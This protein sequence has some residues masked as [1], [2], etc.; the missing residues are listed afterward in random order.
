MTKRTV[1]LFIEIGLEIVEWISIILREKRKGGN[2]DNDTEEKSKDERKSR[3]R[4]RP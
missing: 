3:K 2:K 1:E 4:S